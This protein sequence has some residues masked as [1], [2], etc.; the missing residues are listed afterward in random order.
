MENQEEIH[1][2]AETL[3]ACV[4]STAAREHVEGDKSV[5]AALGMLQTTEILARCTER[6]ACCILMGLHGCFSYTR[7]NKMEFAELLGSAN[8][9]YSDSTSS[10]VAVWPVLS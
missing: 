8:A 5:C 1:T 10:S 2:A 6:A 3:E 4:S 9:S 7:E